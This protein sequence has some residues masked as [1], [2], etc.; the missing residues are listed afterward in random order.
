M[1]WTLVIAIAAGAL[2]VLLLHGREADPRVVRE[3]TDGALRDGEHRAGRTE[4]GDGAAG[5]QDSTDDA[6]SLKGVVVNIEGV[7]VAGATV[8]YEPETDGPL[9]SREVTAITDA[10]G[11]FALPAVRVRSMMLVARHPDYR[12]SHDSVQRDD[13][14]PIRLVIERGAPCHVIVHGPGGVVAGATITAKGHAE[15][16]EQAGNYYSVD[17][18]GAVTGEDGVANLGRVPVGWIHVH[19]KKT[20]LAWETQWFQIKDT[21]PRTVELTLGRGG[22][23][24]G[25]VTAPDGTPVEGARLHHKG[26]TDVLAT[27]DAM[28]RYKITAIGKQGIVPLAEADGHG[29][30]L[31]GGKLGWGKPIRVQAATDEVVD[32]IDIVLGPAS[33]VRGKVVHDDTEGPVPDVKVTIRVENGLVFS[34]RSITGEDGTFELGPITARKGATFWLQ[35]EGSNQSFFSKTDK[36]VPGEDTDVGKIRASP[37]ATIVGKVCDIDGSL[38]AKGYVSTGG[39]T[40]APVTDGVFRLE[41]VTAIR[42]EIVAYG[43]GPTRP[44]SQPV[45]VSL[46]DGETKEVELRLHRTSTISGRVVSDTGAPIAGTWIRAIPKVTTRPDQLGITAWSGEDGEF[47]LPGL[48]PGEYQV[49]LQRDAKHGWKFARKPGPQIVATGTRNVEFQVPVPGGVLRGKVVAKR[50]RLPVLEFGVSLYE[51]VLFVPRRKKYDYFEN[52][53]GAFR[54]DT[55]K[56]GTYFLDVWADNYAV[57]RTK[58]FE[59]K[60]GQTIDVGTIALGEP[61]SLHG[62]VRDHE[63]KP[64]AWCRVYV[65]AGNFKSNYNPPF[66]NRSGRYDIQGLT[67]GTYT[68]FAVSPQHPLAIRRKIEVREGV[69]SRVN[70]ELGAPAALILKI[71]NERGEPVPGAELAWTSPDLKP[72][73]SSMVG[74]RE[75]PGF[76]SNVSDADGVIQKPFLPAGDIEVRIKAKGYALLHQKISL[77]AGKPQT[78][79]IKLKKP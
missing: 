67:P 78:V 6:S 49:G 23:I 4:E 52:D 45:K 2:L 76:G 68:L 53:N 70:V 74:D 31:F 77:E 66:T 63:G 11:R 12:L 50:T 56:A 62:T 69:R 30:G 8:T 1:R 21:S 72:L 32:D 9:A 40:R 51:R 33:R 25:M 18:D 38:L 55:P 27:T 46:D 47:D 24:M 14:E 48:L 22:T 58:E 65:L 43:F 41:N 10:E 39:S 15:S 37:R 60:Q 64:V 42:Q 28:G 5:E 79:E 71:V 75:P 61:G 59:V 16:L 35:F 3:G 57:F 54:F 73:D 26:Q 17:V 29:P 20:G 13:V 44:R 7:P 34:D 36:L 19:A